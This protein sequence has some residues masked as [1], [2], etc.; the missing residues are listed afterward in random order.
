VCFNNK[1]NDNRLK[2]S[3]DLYAEDLDTFIEEFGV[4][5]NRMITEHNP[6]ALETLS[7]STPQGA[8]DGADCAFEFSDCVDVRSQNPNICNYCA[9]GVCGKQRGEGDGGGPAFTCVSSDW[10]P[11]GGGGGGGGGGP[12]PGGGGGGGGGRPLRNLRSV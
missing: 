7:A 5:F 3:V 9:S 12:G 4:V 8:T 2:E 1:P 6:N 11:P 10:T